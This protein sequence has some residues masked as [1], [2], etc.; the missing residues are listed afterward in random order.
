MTEPEHIGETGRMAAQSI[1]HAM[2]QT[3]G[4]RLGVDLAP[5]VLTLADGQRV[6]V[7]GI[8]A[9]ARI[10]VQLVPSA[11][12]PKSHHRNK[13]MAD[14]FKLVWLHEALPTRP[15]AVLCISEPLARF[16]SAGAW[17]RTAA[18]DLGVDVW[19]HGDDGATLLVS[20]AMRD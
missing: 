13:A 3:L 20:A 2:L 7:E 16:F 19:V 1:E 18:R 6:E 17:P 9:A 5:R 12:Q 8:D 10:V 4:G 11:A 14:L 15:R